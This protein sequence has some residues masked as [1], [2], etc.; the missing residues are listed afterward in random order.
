VVESRRKQ[1]DGS[2]ELFGTIGVSTNVIDASW[3]A[4][5]DAYEYH[6]LH[7]AEENAAKE[8]AAVS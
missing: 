3:E 6:L 8:P 4:L 7:V 1:A 5:V 2:T